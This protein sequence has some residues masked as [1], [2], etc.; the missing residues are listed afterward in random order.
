MSETPL[1]LPPSLTHPPLPKRL[2]YK[3]MHPVEK[4]F[5]NFSM[6]RFSQ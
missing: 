5:W 1:P 6:T 2:E 3:R 4:M